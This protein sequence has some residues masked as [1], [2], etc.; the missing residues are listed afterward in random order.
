MLTFL[1]NFFFRFEILLLPF[2]VLTMLNLKEFKRLP[3]LVVFDLDYTLWPFYIDTHHSPPFTRRSDD[4]KTKIVDGSGRRVSYF[5][6]SESILLHLKD[7]PG[8][9]VACASRTGAIDYAKKLLKALNWTDLFDYREIFPG[10]KITHFRNLAKSSGIEF[11]DMLFFDDENRNVVDVQ[12]LGVTCVHAHD[13]MSW[14][15]LKE[16]FTTFE[17]KC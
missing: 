2:L 5:P 3:K 15:V 6:D 12:G 1:K 11:K 8:I 9:S 16:G 13:G 17:K 7:T 14:C 4:N 10:S